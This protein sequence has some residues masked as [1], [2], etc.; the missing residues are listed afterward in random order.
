MIR[1]VALLAVGL[2]AL[3]GI[4]AALLLRPYRGYAG[5]DAT[6]EVR[7]GASADE[8]AEA[9]ARAGVIRSAPF[10]RWLVRIDGSSE[11]LRAGDY[12]FSGPRT[13]FEV[14]DTL[15][16][17]EVVL[18][19]LTVPEGLTLTEVGELLRREGWGEPEPLREALRLSSLIADLDPGATDLEGYLFPD[20]YDFARGTP[21][22]AIVARM[23]A[24]FREV[25]G[26]EERRRARALGWSIRQVVTLASLIEEET[27]VPAER[28]LV[29]SVYRNRLQRGMRL[30]CDPTVLYGL[31]LAGRPR[32]PL[33]RA[34]LTLDSP[35]NTYLHAGLPPG[36]IASPGAAS[37]RAALDPFPSAYLYFVANGHGG[38]Y[39]SRSL[40]EHQRA[41]RLYRR[42]QAAR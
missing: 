14:R 33:R 22:E 25:L 41:V 16:R 13:L 34:D 31:V 5:A 21:P 18:R 32:A 8:I 4:A 26:E 2:L 35:Y 38:H 37:L 29:A 11:R 27:A 36:P 17:G 15:L 42:A 9:L 19:R 12:R 28:S 20:T 1:R 30:Q 39:F 7:R 24:R 3:L 23:T 6:V 10:F 40:P